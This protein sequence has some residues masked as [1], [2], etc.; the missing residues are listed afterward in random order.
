MTCILVSIAIG[1]LR[2]GLL[3]LATER[4]WFAGW[5]QS[6]NLIAAFGLHEQINPSV[7]E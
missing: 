4:V 5:I 2:T 1:I 3:F 6:P 7:V